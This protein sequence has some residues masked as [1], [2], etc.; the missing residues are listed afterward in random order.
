MAVK[1]AVR[2]L[3]SIWLSATA[4]FLKIICL[5]NNQLIERSSFCYGSV[6]CSTAT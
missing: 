5:K 1:G 2:D 3:S 4:K 6:C